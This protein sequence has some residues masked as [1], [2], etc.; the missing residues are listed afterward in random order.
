[1]TSSHKVSKVL[2]EILFLVERIVFQNILEP[3][4]DKALV[5]KSCTKPP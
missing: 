3:Q 4:H 1:M 2:F 5:D